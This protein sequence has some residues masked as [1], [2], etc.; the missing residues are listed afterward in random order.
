MENL[1]HKI[2]IKAFKVI[3]RVL[4]TKNFDYDME[5]GCRG[6]IGQFCK[7]KGYRRVLV[8]TDTAIRGL[9]LLDKLTEEG[10]SQNSIRWTKRQNYRI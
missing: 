6:Q 3:L 2:Y 5:P 4:K 8:V 1:Y 10:K 7:A 9:G